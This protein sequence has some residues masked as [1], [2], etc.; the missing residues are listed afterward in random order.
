[1]Y[2]TIA[3]GIGMYDEIGDKGNGMFTVNRININ[4]HISI[5]ICIYVYM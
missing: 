2:I 5:C 3:T 4:V 1:M